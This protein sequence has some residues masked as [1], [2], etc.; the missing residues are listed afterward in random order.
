M[1]AYIVLTMSN[2]NN[3]KLADYDIILLSTSGGKDSQAMMDFVIGRAIVEGV[4]SR[5]IAV[6]ADLGRVEWKGTKELV[7][8]QCDHYE[9]PLTVVSREKGDL[10]AQVEQRGMW[11]DNKNRYCTSDQ[12]RD[13]ISKV[14]TRITRE[15]Q[16]RNS[17]A[18][19]IRILNCMG[20]RGQESPARAKKDAISRNKRASNGKRLVMDWLPI[21]SWLV[22]QV[23]DVIKTSKCP[24]HYAYDLGMPRLSCVFCIFSSKAALIVAGHENRELLEDYV[25][26]EKKID[27]TFRN[28]F[29]LQSV[30]DDVNAGVRPDRIQ[31]WTM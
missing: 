28:G 9:I 31:D 7:Q 21:H 30:L 6:H 18:R 11:P 5:V 2:E 25:R 29:S 26:I 14:Y 10:L 15:F 19:Q 27:H 20:L 16:E 13:Q 8:K 22:E 23:W 17:T 1:Y 4:H 3:V 12:K 24:Y